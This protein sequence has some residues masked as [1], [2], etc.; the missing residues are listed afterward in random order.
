MVRQFIR[1]GVLVEAAVRSPAE[2]T[3]L[4]AIAEGSNGR[5]RIHRCDV[6]CD[7][8]VAAFADGLGEVP[9]DLLINN[10]GRIPVRD[11]VRAIEPGDRLL[12]TLNVNAVGP[13]RVTRALL[14]NLRAGL[15]RKVVHISSALGSVTDA[16]GGDTFGYRMSKAALNM[17]SRILANGFKGEGIASL[18]VH[19]GWVRTRMGGPRAPLPVQ[20]SVAGILAVIDRLTLRKSGRF[21]DYRGRRMRW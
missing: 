13:L 12:E 19:P 4:N 17:F 11:D 3:E 2:A 21:V 10:A 14:P 20:I 9:V 1:R 5:V 8:S 15:G 7:E 18:V 16:R 6:S